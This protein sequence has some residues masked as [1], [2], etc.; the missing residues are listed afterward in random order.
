MIVYIYHFQCF[1]KLATL[2]KHLGKFVK[3]ADSALSPAPIPPHS[4]SDQ[5]SDFSQ[6]HNWFVEV[7]LAY[8]EM[9]YSL[10]FE[11]KVIY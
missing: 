2:K 11:E 10:I 1:L 5:K 4:D 9:Y 7:V 6:T 3:N 8:S